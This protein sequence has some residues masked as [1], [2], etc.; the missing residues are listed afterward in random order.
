ME[1]MVSTN[2]LFFAETSSKFQLVWW[3]GYDATGL[4]LQQRIIVQNHHIQ[5]K[6]IAPS[7]I[8]TFV[9][10]WEVHIRKLA[11]MIC[12]ASCLLKFF[13]YGFATDSSKAGMSAGLLIRETY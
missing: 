4:V 12:G 11:G 8:R 6:G 7:T 9:F 13:F 1:S 5:P 2:P 10:I 3:H